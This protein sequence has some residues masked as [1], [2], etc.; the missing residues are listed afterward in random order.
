MPQGT[1]DI[2]ISEGRNLKD[3]NTY[4]DKN[5]FFEAY[6]NKNFKQRTNMVSNTNDIIWNEQLSFNIKR[7]GDDTLH[8]DIYEDGE[9]LIGKCKIKLK[10]VLNDG[11]YNEWI[12]I[13][14]MYGSK[15]HGEIH[16]IMK[17]EVSHVIENNYMPIIHSLI[18]SYYLAIQKEKFNRTTII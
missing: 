18:S 11:K 17:F 5:I 8:F 16:V 9:V 1:L 12:K 2:I 6:I 4:D 3:E 7:N 10:R 15:S 14:V 13:P